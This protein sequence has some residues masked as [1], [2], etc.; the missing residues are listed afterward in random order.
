LFLSQSGLQNIATGKILLIRLDHI[1]D[2]VLLTPVFKLLREKFPAA[3]IDL[4][5]GSWTKEIVE[6]NA[7]LNDI[8]EFDAYWFNRAKDK[9]FRLKTYTDMLTRLRKEKYD[10][11]FE[12]RGDARTILLLQLAGFKKFIGYSMTGLGFLLDHELLFDVNR[13]QVHKNLALLQLFGIDT[14]KAVLDVP[15]DKT[16]KQVVSDTM[17]SLNLNSGDKKIVCIHPGVGRPSGRWPLNHFAQLADMLIESGKFTVLLLNNDT[18]PDKQAASGIRHAM[19]YGDKIK[20]LDRKLNLRQLK[21]LIGSCAVFIGLESGP[22]H[23][24]AA[25]GVKGVS[26]FSGI[27]GITDF[28]PWNKNIRVIRKQVKC[29]PCGKF[30]CDNNICMTEIT[31]GE[32]YKCVSELI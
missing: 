27:V 19:K 25:T 30:E 22:A 13:H 2:M 23:L 32:I 8:I 4:M 16:D 29:S 17:N 5:I 18:E 28:D 21:Q 7:Y 9:Q 31:P 12:F 15:V 24:A 26:I 14:Q 3:K 1:G 11:A 20:V 10:I 6:K